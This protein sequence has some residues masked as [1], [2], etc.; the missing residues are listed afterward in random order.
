M[1]KIALS[2]S[3]MSAVIKMA[4]DN[5]GAMAAMMEIFNHHDAIDPQAAMGGMG[6]IMLFD[7]WGIYGAGIYVIWNDKCGRDVRRML[8]LVRS[9]QLGLL[10]KRKLVDMASDQVGQVDLTVDEWKHLDESVCKE[11]KEFASG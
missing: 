11:L 1:G 7:T 3:V 10:P 4:E 2:D 5:P 8:V 6:T 9:V